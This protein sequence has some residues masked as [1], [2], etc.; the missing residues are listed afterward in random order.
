M[1]VLLTDSPYLSI[2]FE[3]TSSERSHLVRNPAIY[4]RLMPG[5][6]GPFAPTQDTSEGQSH[7][8]NSPQCKPRILLRLCCSMTSPTSES[9]FLPFSSTC[10]DSKNTPE[11]NKCMLISIS[12]CFLGDSA[13]H[14]ICPWDNTSLEPSLFFF[15]VLFS[16]CWLNHR[17][18]FV[19]LSHLICSVLFSP[20][21]LLSLSNAHLTTTFIRNS[22]LCFVYQVS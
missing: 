13:Y 17:G 11:E 1:E 19:W 14:T 16:Q 7:L 4:D 9:Y 18:V 12:D 22:S 20:F 3:S 6:K 21:F 2:L 8:Q 10:V 5:D 15:L